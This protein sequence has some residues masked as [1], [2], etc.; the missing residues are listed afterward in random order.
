MDTSANGLDHECSV[1]GA[2]CA[3]VL[4]VNNKSNRSIC[5]YGKLHRSTNKITQVWWSPDSAFFLT[6]RVMVRF[7][8]LMT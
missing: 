2:H 7:I 1:A 8:Q 5:A 6:V 4:D 3:V